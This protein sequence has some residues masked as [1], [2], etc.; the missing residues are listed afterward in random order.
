[1]STKTKC[2]DRQSRFLLEVLLFEVIVAIPFFPCESSYYAKTRKKEK[3]WLTVTTVS[4]CSFVCFVNGRP[5]LNLKNP[6]SSDEYHGLYHHRHWLLPWFDFL[7][8]RIW[9]FWFGLRDCFA[10]WRSRGVTRP[11]VWIKQ[12]V[13][14]HV[15]PEK[16]RD[17]DNP[18]PYLLN[19]VRENKPKRK[20]KGTEIVLRT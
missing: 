16:H 17:E 12:I 18:H 10:P 14:Y 20:R 5:N 19:K 2:E 3:S 7:E 15:V 13:E 8:K 9:I 11:I 4:F 1:M 6:R